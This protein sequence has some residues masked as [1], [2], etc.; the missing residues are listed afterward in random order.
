MTIR[1]LLESLVRF[2]WGD[3][4]RS[5]RARWVEDRLGVSAGSLTFT[6]IIALVPFFTVVLALFTAFPVFGKLQGVVQSWLVQSLV[7]D[8]I[9]RQVLGYLTQFATKASRLGTFGMLFLLVTAL[10]LVLTIDRTL[11]AIWRVRQ[12][13]PLGQ[14]VLVYWAVIT[15]G[16]L[17]LAGSLSLSSYV[18][19]ASRGLVRALPGEVML[20]LD[21]GE[22]VL[23]TACLAALYR[24]VPNTP[25]LRAHA[26]AGALLAA[27]GFEISRRLLALYIGAV[28]TYSAV[29]GAFATVPILLVW[30]YLVWMVILL[31]AVL[32]AHL[33]R[34]MAGSTRLPD[35]PGWRFQLALEAARAL[36][37][38]RGD[39]R[40]GLALTRLAREMRVDHLLLEPVVEIMVGLGWVGRLDE[41]SADEPARLVLLVDP[42]Q[43]PLAPLADRL[44]LPAAVAEGSIQRRLLGLTLGEALGPGALAR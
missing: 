21:L 18:L 25:V 44:L 33:P 31:G 4:V 10:S 14:R 41:D 2:P 15:L 37:A 34:L 7:P 9:A 13:R 17:V 19:S 24:Y 20:L 42:A 22:F 3:A 28:P 43:V 29:Y 12:A 27:L 23:L 32:A 16:P 11:N 35:G 40:G 26:W 30:I 1:P 38:A 6:T 36:A 39:G 8:T 5:L